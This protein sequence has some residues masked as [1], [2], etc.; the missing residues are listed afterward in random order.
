MGLYLAV[1]DADEELEGVEVG[2]YADFG[3]FRDTV[4]RLLEGGATG[5][6]FPTLMLHSDCEGSW[7]L[8][9][10]ARLQLEL[11]QIADE[12]RRLPPLDLKPDTWQV[13]V[14]KTLGIRPKNLYESFFDVDG[15]PLI[16]RLSDLIR[17]SRRHGRQILFQ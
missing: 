4:A 14:A 3:V 6:R 10:A 12:L 9:D 5:S 13:E 11:D 17:V 8:D 2:S 16:E 1:F 7:S 15:E